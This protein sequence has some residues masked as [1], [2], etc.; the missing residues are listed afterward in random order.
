MI[1]SNTNQAV[2]FLPS[3]NL[4][5]DNDR[6]TDFFRRAQAWLVSH[7]IGDDIEELLEFDIPE[8][9]TDYH[10]EL[11]RHCQRVIA[12]KALLDAIPEMDLQLTEAGFAVQSN[13]QLKPASS[14]RVDRLL[15]KLPNRMAAD[16]DALVLFLIENST[17]EG[18]YDEWRDTQQ[19]N[20]LTSAFN[21]Y[22][23]Q[24]C[25]MAKPA[26]IDYE[27]FYGRIAQV[28]KETVKVGDY[29]VSHEEI[30]RLLGLYRTEQT[31]PEQ[32]YVI[33]EI[34]KIGVA[35]VDGDMSRA[36]DCAAYARLLMMDDIDLFPAFANS[37]A[38]TEKDINLD[39]GRLVNF[40]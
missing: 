21:P 26:E 11:R 30:E 18:Q 22:W 19:Y 40:L 3:L 12:E 33:G 35:A 16:A 13:D 2:E 5:L 6:F 23:K 39:G 34:R 9:A 28:A 4:T 8:G 37:K 24:Y 25:L 29:F 36:R 31:K 32:R 38:Y 17:S 27:L 7:I 14:Q 1:L 20:Y 10:G 15:A